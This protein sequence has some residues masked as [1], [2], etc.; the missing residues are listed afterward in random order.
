MRK[1]LLPLLSVLVIAQNSQS[2]VCPNPN[3]FTVSIVSN[4][5]WSPKPSKYLSTLTKE[6]ADRVCSYEF[7]ELTAEMVVPHGACQLIGS[8]F[9]CREG[10]PDDVPDCPNSRAGEEQSLSTGGTSPVGWIPARTAVTKFRSAR[11]IHLQNQKSDTLI[12]SYDKKTVRLASF[13]DMKPLP[14]KFSKQDCHE[15]KKEDLDFNYRNSWLDIRS[16][17]GAL[18]STI[19]CSNSKVLKPFL[20]YGEN[21]G[22][23]VSKLI[24]EKGLLVLNGVGS[25]GEDSYSEYIDLK[26]CDLL[27][28]GD[29]QFSPNKDFGI[30]SVSADPNAEYG[31][32]K[33]SLVIL[34]CRTGFCKSILKKDLGS[35]TIVGLKWS[36]DKSFELKLEKQISE[37]NSPELKKEFAKKNKPKICKFEVLK[38]KA[39][40][41][42]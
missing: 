18:S 32:G 28:E 1:S 15:I 35:D 3:Q 37:M 38:S 6:P 20:E 19:V 11:L 29:I 2:E 10:L 13:Q 31:G 33:S 42:R 34:D 27:G 21:G 39:L 16:A 41:C 5:A 22:T 8:K 25:N 24:C 9:S 26:S 30:T 17:P 23:S 14:G 12:C 36:S 4:S 40:D 7:S